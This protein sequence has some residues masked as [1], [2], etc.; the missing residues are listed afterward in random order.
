[1]RRLAHPESFVTPAQ[2]AA[3]LRS[4]ADEIEERAENDLMISVKI[5]RRWSNREHVDYSL[6]EK[7]KESHSHE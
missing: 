5:E 1:M 7:M 4:I 2:A 6:V 3:V